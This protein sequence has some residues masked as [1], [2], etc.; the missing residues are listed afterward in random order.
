LSSKSTRIPPWLDSAAGRSFLSIERV[1]VS[2]A[3]RQM[4]GPCVVQIGQLID[5]QGLRELDFPQWILVQENLSSEPGSAEISE[6]LQDQEAN[7]QVVIADA[8]FLP[9]DANSVSIVVLPH[10][11]ETH[12]L[13]HQVLREAHRILRPEGHLLLT[14]FNPASI[15]GLQRLLSNRSAFQGQYYTVK[16]VK[17]WLQLLGFEIVASA[18]HQYAP[19]VKR[20]S[21]RK[22]LNFINS[23]GD[24]WLPMSGGGYMISAK[25][26]E[27]GFTFVGKLKFSK[28]A[29]VRRKLTTAATKTNLC[30]K[31]DE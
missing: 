17:D 26:R 29:R 20:P 3:L 31:S 21:L 25:K 12:E 10:V 7:P 5:D 18:M 8:A 16:R 13:P 24:R 23:A 15:L 6:T 30:T 9:F 19:L 4:A 14:G 1:S 11:L 28:R 2:A 27:S 22:A